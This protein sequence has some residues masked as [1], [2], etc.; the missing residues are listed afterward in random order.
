MGLREHDDDTLFDKILLDG[1]QAGL[2]WLTILNCE[3]P[4][5]RERS[6]PLE[7]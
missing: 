5:T 1:A 2:G 4:G 3:S 6:V 7:R